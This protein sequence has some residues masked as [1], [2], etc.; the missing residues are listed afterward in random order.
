MTDDPKDDGFLR[1]SRRFFKHFLWAEGRTYSKA[2][3]WLD[4]VAQC[5]YEPQKRIVAGELVHVPRGG[6]VASE[7]YLATRWKWSRTKIRAFFDLLE[8][9]GMILI[10][11]KDHRISSISLC[12]FDKYNPQKDRGSDHRKATERPLTRPP[13]DQIQEEEEGKDVKKLNHS[14]PRR[15]WS[16]EEVAAAGNLAS[17][18]PEVCKLYHDSREAVGWVDRNA[19][20]IK[21]M[22]HDLAKFAAH[23]SNNH[24]QKKGQ[25]NG[26][27]TSQS[28]VRKYHGCGD[29]T[30]Y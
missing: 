5:A 3:A 15:G 7:R 9:E 28:R 11:P 19:I 12:N 16:L 25:H 6:V 22:P 8:K 13:K 24:A 20:P 14:M 2:E 1:L 29:P 27:K 18:P 26:H 17:V 23:Y 10:P 21:S 30:G 4:L